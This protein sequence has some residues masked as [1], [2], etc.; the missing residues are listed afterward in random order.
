[1]AIE[2][3][4]PRFERLL[5]RALD[6]LPR[7]FAELLD[8]VAVVIEEEPS[9]EDLRL[10]GLDPEEDDLLG[11]YHGVPLDERGAGYS[12][13]PDRVVIYRLPIL[14]ICDT[15]GDVV[16]EVRDTLVHELGHHFGLGD[17]DMPY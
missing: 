9:E 16:R 1:M 11:L 6:T 10:V 15:E 7:A 5:A 4:L 3:D 8:N 13:L 14:W 12:S 2:I 17:D